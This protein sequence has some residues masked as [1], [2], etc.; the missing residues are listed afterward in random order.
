MPHDEPKRTFEN[1]F[2]ENAKATGHEQ[3]F[4]TAVISEIA[5]TS[6]HE[7]FEAATR[8][9]KRNHRML[10]PKMIGAGRTFLYFAALA[11]AIWMF[12]PLPQS[13][14]LARLFAPNEL[15]NAIYD[16][17]TAE[18]S[19]DDST[20]LLV[21]GDES[22]NDRRSRW[23][24]LWMSEPDNPAWFS[25][26]VAMRLSEEGEL[27]PQLLTEASRIDPENGFWHLVAACVDADDFVERVTIPETEDQPR[28]FEIHATDEEAVLHRI[29]R[30]HQAVA[31]RIVESRHREWYQA[32]IPHM[33]PMDVMP[34]RLHTI[35]LLAGE[36]LYGGIHI[37]KLKDLQEAAMRIAVARNDSELATILIHDWHRIC[38]LLARDA[39]TIIEVL[40]THV[41]VSQQVEFFYQAAQDLNLEREVELLEPILSAVK[42]VEKH[43]KEFKNRSDHATDSH[44]SF[45]LKGSMLA[46]LIPIQAPDLL[47]D[48]LDKL[49]VESLRPSRRMEHVFVERMMI[50]PIAMVTAV[51]LV[52]FGLCWLFAGRVRRAFA[53]RAMMMMPI[54]KL[55]VFGLLAAA[56]PLLWYLLITR[57]TP[58]GWHE[59]SL[60]H[61]TRTLFVQWG[62][63]AFLI[64]FLPGLLAAIMFEKEGA[65]FGWRWPGGCKTRIVASISILAALPA[66]GMI[67]FKVDPSEFHFEACWWGSIAILAV[68]AIA[69]LWSWGCQWL[70]SRVKSPRRLAAGLFAAHARLVTLA[71]LLAWAFLTHFEEKSWAAR[72]TLFVVNPASPALSS[73]EEEIQR[74]LRAQ[75]LNVLGPAWNQ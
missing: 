29:Q 13:P 26:Y 31:M 11:S 71:L 17:A 64:L 47:I 43:R 75:V 63:L 72:D 74:R 19:L 58:L 12:G 53:R 38:Q 70:Q 15:L 3:A 69:T 40:I 34:N 9:L 23:H 2:A 68:V 56:G 62:T 35:T 30:V 61:G 66:S 55:A 54:W 48:R 24:A 28:K 7:A 6:T 18:D 8:R 46:G 37:R 50:A 21:Y 51:S 67:S 42:D 5:E 32:A 45:T 65:V 20:R 25:R 27:D 41:L 33:P 36:I 16:P 14:S 59:W 1:A 73:N 44:D 52:I 22:T 49:D 4:C 10:H 39:S 60:T 57:F